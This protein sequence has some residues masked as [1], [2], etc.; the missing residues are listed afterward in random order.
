M[1]FEIK[2]IKNEEF[3]NGW[4]FPIDEIT[5]ISIGDQLYNVDDFN[6]AQEFRDFVNENYKQ[7]RCEIKYLERIA[8]DSRR[9]QF[10][11]C[12]EGQLIPH[13]DGKK[14]AYECYK[15]KKAKKQNSEY[16]NEGIEYLLR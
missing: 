10:L 6:N 4:I 7:N 13:R 11:M 1:K 3:V 14:P 15:I 12:K 9:V 2:K 5:L 8:N 16:Y